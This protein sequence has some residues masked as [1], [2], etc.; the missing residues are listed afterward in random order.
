MIRIEA[1]ELNKDQIIQSF[2]KLS[3]LVNRQSGE[4]GNHSRVS[5]RRGLL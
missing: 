1:G 5:R 3:V 2:V 4:I